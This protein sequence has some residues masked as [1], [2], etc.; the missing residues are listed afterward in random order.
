MANQDDLPV[1]DTDNS[2]ITA[3]SIPPPNLVATT[4][5]MT[6]PTRSVRVTRTRPIVAWIVGVGIAVVAVVMVVLLVGSTGSSPEHAIAEA[7]NLHASDLPG[8]TVQAANHSSAGKQIDSRMRDCLGAGWIAHH[9]GGELADVSS[10]QF[11]SGSGLQAEQV[12]SSVT[13]KTSVN[14]VSTDL[15]AINSGRIQHCFASA[16]DGVTIPTRAGLILTIGNVEVTQLAVSSRGSDGSFGIRTTMTMSALGRSIPLV[17]DIL[18][19][20]VG[21]D[22]LGLFTF[23]VGQ[24]F[25]SPAEQQLASLLI[26]RALARPH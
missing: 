1:G 13:I 20:A 16:L 19:Y 8:F 7:I 21:K 23:A 22:E 15:A 12:G 25:S 9:S 11:T 14:A 6:P 5:A 10:P 24:P 18:G 3:T 17:L 2:G 4:V 26:T